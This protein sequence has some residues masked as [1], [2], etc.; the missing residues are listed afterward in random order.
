ME[1][2]NIQNENILKSVETDID[3]FDE[4]H[5]VRAK[6]LL[7]SDLYSTQIKLMD[8]RDD[9]QLLA[10]RDRLTKAIGRIDKRLQKV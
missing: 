7:Q 5:L 1:F 10:D 3:S 8:R 4:N 2:K 6:A 9:A